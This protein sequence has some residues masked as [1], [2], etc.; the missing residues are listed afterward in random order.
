[1]Q[2]NF[3]SVKTFSGNVALKITKTISLNLKSSANTLHT[4]W[5]KED[6]MFYVCFSY[7]IIQW[8]SR[9]VSYPV[10]RAVATQLFLPTRKPCLTILFLNGGNKGYTDYVEF[11]MLMHQTS[12]TLKPRVLQIC[13]HLS[14]K[15]FEILFCWSL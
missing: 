1:M 4:K 6:F 8:F 3:D 7:T 14:L 13:I 9:E 15:V 2:K 5:L 10:G 12:P 11:K